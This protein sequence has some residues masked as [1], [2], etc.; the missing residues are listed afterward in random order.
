MEARKKAKDLV[1]KMLLDH[2]MPYYLA[3][4]CA[5]IAIDEILNEYPCQCPKDSYEMERHLFWKKVK[6]EIEKL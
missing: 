2:D 6:E 1:N 5:L 3:N 4:E